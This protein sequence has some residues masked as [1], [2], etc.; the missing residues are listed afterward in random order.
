M[1]VVEDILRH[2]AVLK[3]GADHEAVLE[4]L[5]ALDALSIPVNT[6]VDTRVGTYVRK[7]TSHT[8]PAICA[9]SRQLMN[10]WSEIIL[11][12]PRPLL[13]V[14]RGGKDEKIRRAHR[15]HLLKGLRRWGGHLARPS[16]LF[17]RLLT[18]SAATTVQNAGA[19]QASFC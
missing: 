19:L 14:E 12:P 11:A 6:L 9:Q 13:D 15:E 17:C 1:V 8:N 3:A 18:L 10:K 2:K 5:G 7:L 16:T 4:S